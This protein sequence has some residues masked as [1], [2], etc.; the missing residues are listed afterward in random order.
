MAKIY[1]PTEYLN[2]ACYVI[3]NGYIR[4]YETINN[5]NN[6]IYDIYINQ[7]YMVKKS[8]G[9][10]SSYTVCDTVNTYTDNVYYRIDFPQILLMLIILLIICFYLPYRI[11]SRILGKWGKF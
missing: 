6:T 5:S 3:N 11:M 10:Y 9:N 4:V 8:T 1:V 2:K 7:D